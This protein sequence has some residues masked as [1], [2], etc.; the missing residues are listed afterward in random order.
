MQIYLVKDI[1]SSSMHGRRALSAS[2][3]PYFV[4][5][6]SEFCLQLDESVFPL[7]ICPWARRRRGSL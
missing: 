2:D 5:D 6:E 4:H 3:V 1:S 7:L